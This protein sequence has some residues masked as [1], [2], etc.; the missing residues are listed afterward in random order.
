MMKEV[1]HRISENSDTYVHHEILMRYSTCYS[2]FAFYLSFFF[3]SS[4]LDKLDNSV[5]VIV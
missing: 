4:E 1:R 5:T 2:N 3:F